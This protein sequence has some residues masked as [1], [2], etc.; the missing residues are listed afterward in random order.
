MLLMFLLGFVLDFIEITFVVVPIVGPI[1]LAMG[2]DPV[3]LG[4]MIALN[5]QTSF[6]TAFR[7][8]ALLPARRRAAGVDH[9][10]DLPRRR[11]L[12]VDSACDAGGAGGLA[13]ASYLA[14]ERRL[15][16]LTMLRR[17]GISLR[18]T[19]NRQCVIRQVSGLRPRL[20]RIAASARGSRS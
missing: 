8:C 3:W 11:A 4:V 16:K 17:S 9:R 13:A 19:G 2:L 18:H 10:A 1:L 12:C 6:D 14:S 15:R 5:L 7:F 20:Y